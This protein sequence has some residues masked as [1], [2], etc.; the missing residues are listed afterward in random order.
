MDRPIAG[1]AGKD[2]K[3]VVDRQ[4]IEVARLVKRGGKVRLVVKVRS[5]VAKHAKLRAKVLG[6][7]GRKLGSW[8]KKVRTNQKVTL[9]VSA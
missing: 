8:T 9:R 2:G 4:W 5:D 6:K 1:P 3:D 7:R